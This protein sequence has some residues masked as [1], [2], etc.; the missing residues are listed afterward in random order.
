MSRND[1][2]SQLSQQLPT[3]IDRLTPQGRVP[4]EDEM[5]RLV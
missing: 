4:T 5:S 2:L 1:L 3:M